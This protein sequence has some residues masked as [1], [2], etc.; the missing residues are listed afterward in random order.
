MLHKFLSALLFKY[1]VDGI[2]FNEIMVKIIDKKKLKISAFG[3]KINL[4]KHEI[5]HEIK[6]VTY[7]QLEVKRENNYWSTRVIFDI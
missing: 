5:K 7:H 4:E 3:E 2:V 1:E 6:A